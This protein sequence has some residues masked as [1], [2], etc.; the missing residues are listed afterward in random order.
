MSNFSG[1]SNYPPG[2]TGNEYAISGAEREWTEERECPL[3][4]V[5]QVMDHE[6]HREFGVRAWCNNPDCDGSD[7]FDVEP[8]DEFEYDPTSV[9]YRFG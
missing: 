3:C 4:G 7:G 6:A 8:V 1:L 5:T 2:V 9:A